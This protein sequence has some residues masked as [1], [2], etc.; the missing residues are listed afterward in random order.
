M[1]SQRSLGTDSLFTSLI[2]TTPLHFPNIAGNAQVVPNPSPSESFWRL[3]AAMHITD[4]CEKGSLL[5]P[6][7][8]AQSCTKLSKSLPCFIDQKSVQNRPSV[9]NFQSTNWPI[10]V[11]WYPF[12]FG[13][14]VSKAINHF[15]EKVY[16]WPFL[17][18]CTAFSIQLSPACS[19]SPVIPMLI[20]H[21]LHTNPIH[22][23]VE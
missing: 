12:S 11:Q 17:F 15:F 21:H 2:T 10:R 13:E 23:S 9:D 19:P 14:S 6:F 3:L 16:S 22:T 4:D 7:F 18:F 8:F 1:Q 5:H 20:S